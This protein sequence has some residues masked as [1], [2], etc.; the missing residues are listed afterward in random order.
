MK[1]SIF[2]IAIVLLLTDCKDIPYLHHKLKFEKVS[3]NCSGVSSKLEINSN[4]NGDRYE[5]NKC[6]PDNFVKENATIK[7]Q[8]DTVVVSFENSKKMKRSDFHIILDIDTYPRY[9]FLTIDGETFIIVPTS[10]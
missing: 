8:G 7:R 9:N 2:C 10:G 4:I 1:K 3:D 6:L 5:F